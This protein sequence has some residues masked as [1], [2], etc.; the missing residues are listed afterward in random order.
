[1]NRLEEIIGYKFKNKELLTRALTHTSFANEH[2]DFRESNER[3][4]FLGDA[5][6]GLTVAERLFKNY[7][8]KPEGDLTRMRAMLVCEANLAKAA[9]KISLG[10][11]L[12]MGKGEQ[13][14]GGNQRASVLSDA[15][16]AVIA[17][18]YLDGGIDEAVKFIH[19]FLLFDV[20]QFKDKNTVDNKSALQALVQKTPN[21]VLKYELISEEGP[22]HMK[23]FHIQVTINDKPIAVGV[24]KSKQEAGQLAAAKA[25]E[26]LENEA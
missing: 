24:G 23:T 10:D 22:A 19:K 17:A 11:F 8:D 13:K 16:E 1:M 14:G 5:I 6:L 3:L 15:Y 18:I 26:I 25:L 20:E 2:G 12:L 9:Q 4:E 21:N 7:K